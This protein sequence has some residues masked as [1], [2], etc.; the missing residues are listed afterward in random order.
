VSA[1]S[2]LY[3]AAVPLVP[4]PARLAVLLSGRGSNF[5]A[6]AQACERGEL[7]AR[8]VAVISD[9]KDAEGL[10]H[11]EGRLLPSFLVGGDAL[12]GG[13][14]REARILEILSRTGVDLICLAGFMRLL[15][16]EFVERFPLRILN[17]H[18]S[19]L[20]SFPGLDAHGQALRSGVRV[21]GATVHFVDAGT[22]SGP[23][24]GQAAVPILPD[25]DESSL[26]A[27]I[28]PVEHRLYVDALRRV[29]A[30]G[31]SVEGRVVRF[32]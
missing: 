28:L 11:A 10:R 8:I 9:K 1:R 22:D 16:S 27:R 14:A 15:S 24:V 25:D 3:R 31:W 29:L 12:A 7:P 21:T 32:L 23:I 20:P 26:S 19:L 6:I 5:E 17:V 2:L 18:P 4:L 13:S 30:G